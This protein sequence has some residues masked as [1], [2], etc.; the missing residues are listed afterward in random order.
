V[1]RPRSTPHTAHLAPNDNDDMLFDCDVGITDVDAAI[2][3]SGLIV[4]S[5]NGRIRNAWVTP[6]IHIA[7]V[8]ASQILPDLVDVF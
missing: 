7:I 3:E 5:T 6:P 4:V 8:R 2:A 1:Q